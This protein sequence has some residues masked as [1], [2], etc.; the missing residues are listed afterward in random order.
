MSHSLHL[1]D[2]LDL[3]K[4]IPDNSVDSVVCDPPYGLSFMGKAWDYD[5]PK[6]DIWKECLRVLKPGGHLLAFAGTR[7]QHRMAVNIEDAGFEIRDMIAWVYGCYSEDTECLTKEGWKHYTQLS[8]ND[9]IMQ[10][11]SN[12]D[13]FSWTNPLEI[14]VYDAPKS[15]VRFSNRHTDQLLTENHR[16]YLKHKTN[17]RYKYGNFDVVEAGSVKKSW[18]KVFPLASKLEGGVYVNNAYMIGWWMTDAW[19]HGDGKACMFSQSKPE[20][21]QKLV[22]A[23]SSSDCKFSEYI[24]KAKKETH[25]DEHTF[26]VI[27]NLS[28][29]LISNFKDRSIGYDVL[30]WDYQSRFNL[31]EGLLDGDGSRDEKR[32]SETFWSN[33]TER[34]DVVSALC[35]SLGIRNHIDYEKGCV[36]LN[37]TKQTTELQAKHVVEKVKYTGSK[38]WCLKTETG[39][40]VVRRCGKPF[41]SGNSGFPKSLDISKAIDKVAGGRKVT[42]DPPATPE[43]QQW[44]G[45]G[46]ALKPALEPVT[47]ARKPLVSTVTE[48]VLQWGT[49]GLNIDGCRIEYDKDDH[50]MKYKGY[51][52]GSYKSEYEGGTSYK[53]GTQVQ[54]NPSGRW[55]A[56]LIHDGSDE[57]VELFPQTGPS[58]GG[59]AFVGARGGNTYQNKGGG[60]EKRDPGFGDSGSAARFFYCAKTSKKERGEGNNHPTV[61][62]IALMAYLCRLVTPPNGTVLDP[63][64]GSGSTG[65]AASQ[66]NFNFIGIEMD[67]HYFNIARRRIE[68]ANPLSA[69]MSED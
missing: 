51:S 61:K 45:W 34:L 44:Q 29:Y 52:D 17:S 68:S 9:L 12:T 46:T 26:Y 37:R 15:M 2:C 13:E 53:H 58:K 55:P 3:M 59:A 56:N 40:F 65:L 39:A 38:V 10:W 54:I 69:F 43:A 11:D 30:G 47:V 35:T 8:K 67:E 60:T 50:V 24:K 36:Y 14:F 20:K 27:G 62:P 48:N 4:E 23:L 19:L 32:H 18:L 21:L 33:K 25:Q 64:M 22:N 5:V 1:G 41:I 6:V 42:I 28:E 49:G 31:L 7:T 66:E 57:V 63:F 16:V